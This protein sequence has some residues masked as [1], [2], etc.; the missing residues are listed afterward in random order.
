[1]G[2]ALNKANRGL[3]EAV[4]VN[5]VQAPPPR[6]R[7]QSLT[8]PTAKGYLPQ[9]WSTLACSSQGPPCPVPRGVRPPSISLCASPELQLPEQEL[10]AA[11]ARTLA[12]ASDF[13]PPCPFIDHVWPYSPSRSHSL[14]EAPPLACVV[15]E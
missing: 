6:G 9:A 13:A 12:L 14:A 5:G 11:G 15:R 8:P 3:G 10:T 2:E 4:Q 1:M 7:A